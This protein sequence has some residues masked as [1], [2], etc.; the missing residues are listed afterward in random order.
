MD[1]KI[2]GTG[3]KK[4][5]ALT[6][7]VKEAIS[8]TTVEA[9]IEKVEDMKDIMGYGVMSTPA[10]VIDGKVVSTGR[11]LSVDEAKKLIKE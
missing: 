10:V 4:C 2:L 11:V 9:S 5:N 3:C 7:N 8:E 6:N 1:I